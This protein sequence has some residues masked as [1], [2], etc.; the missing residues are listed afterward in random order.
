MRLPQLI[1]LSLC[2]C[3]GALTSGCASM[4]QGT[5]QSAV[6]NAAVHD[7]LLNMNCDYR[8]DGVEPPTRRV[9]F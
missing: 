7:S 6:Q 9:A 2:V 5:D 8:R 3:L 4:D 1:G